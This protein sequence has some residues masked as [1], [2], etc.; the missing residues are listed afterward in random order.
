MTSK[1]PF[2]QKVGTEDNMVGRSSVSS[3]KL[4]QVI[5][6]ECPIK[7]QSHQHLGL[8]KLGTPSLP[9]HSSLMWY[10][11]LLSPFRLAGACYRTL[12]NSWGRIPGGH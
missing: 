2:S 3:R 12:D 8:L 5:F 4:T 11:S 7:L 1:N 9:S 6:G 10:L